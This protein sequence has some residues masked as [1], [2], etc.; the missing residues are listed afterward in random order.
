MEDI[1]SKSINASL[2][3]VEGAYE[4]L[5]AIRNKKSEEEIKRIR[6]LIIEHRRKKFAKDYKTAI[7][8]G[9]EHDFEPEVYNEENDEY[10]R[11]CKT[12][13]HINTYEKM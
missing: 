5:E 9:H 6:Q 8:V 11:K 10:H 13:G 3:H 7:G 4:L 12:C 2:Q 1:N